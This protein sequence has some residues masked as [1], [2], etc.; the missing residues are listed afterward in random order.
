MASVRAKPVTAA[1]T[2]FERIRPST[3]C[4]TAIDVMLT[5]RPHRRSFIPGTTARV[6]LRTLSRFW[7]SPRHALRMAL[8]RAR[9]RPAGVG[10]QH[11]DAA[12]PGESRIH[13]RSPAASDSRPR[14]AGLGAGLLRDL[15][16]GRPASRRAS[17]ARRRI[18]PRRAPGRPRGRAR[19]WRRR[20][21]QSSLQ[22]RSTARSYTGLPVAS[23]FSRKIRLSRSSAYRR[24]PRASTAVASDT[25]RY[26]STSPGAAG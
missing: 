4:F 11:V 16:R 19:G 12:E 17:T 3:G 7:R 20:R 2:L 5:M 18:L 23:G 8:E 6:R 1:R 24:K 26:G 21:E 14:D 9:R 10:H 25:Y 22:P 15:G 13:D